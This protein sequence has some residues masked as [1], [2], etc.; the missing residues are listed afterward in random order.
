[1]SKKKIFSG[2]WATFEY[3]D[4][5]CAAIK[6]LK[7][8]GFA[9]ITTHTPCPRH[10][11]DHALGDPQS[12]IPFFTLTGAF[13]G[14][15]VAVL[16]MTKTALDWILPVSGKPILGVPSMGPISF[17][18]AVLVAIYCTMGGMF[19]LIIRDSKKHPVPSSSKYKNY[20]R[21]MRDRFGVVVACE[22]NDLDKIENILKKHQAEEVNLE[23]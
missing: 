6:E 11:I 23:K 1:M 2:G 12:R 8:E 20:D 3:L 5:T 10:E 15:S 4:D 17:E 13:I 9:R 16:L 22:N 7:K 19:F 21:F 14:F 18:F